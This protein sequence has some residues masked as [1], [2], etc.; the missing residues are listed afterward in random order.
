[1]IQCSL[2]IWQ[3][4]IVLLYTLCVL[5]WQIFW[6]S[7]FLFVHLYKLSEKLFIYSTLFLNDL[8]I[9]TCAQL[10]SFLARISMWGFF[11]PRIRIEPHRLFPDWWFHLAS[12]A[13]YHI[14]STVCLSIPHREAV[15]E[16]PQVITGEA[17]SETGSCAVD[18]MWLCIW[19]PNP[20]SQF[21]CWWLH[22]FGFWVCTNLMLA[23][24][25][26]PVLLLYWTWQTHPQINNLFFNKILD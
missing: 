9:H 23:R 26:R 22:S 11:F 18:F 10:P 14:I 21:S 16:E 20:A 7:S 24:G 25:Y 15:Q 17:G 12:L 19:V 8:L 13:L 5:L 1:M 2:Q 3:S 6:D 4:F